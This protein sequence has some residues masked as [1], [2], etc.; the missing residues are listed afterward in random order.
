MTGHLL[1]SNKHFTAVDKGA[2][3]S[4]IHTIKKKKPSLVRIITNSKEAFSERQENLQTHAQNTSP[5]VIIT[6]INP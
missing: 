3:A 1:L 2:M 5:P 6:E 4:V